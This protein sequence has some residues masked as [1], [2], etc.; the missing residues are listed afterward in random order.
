MGDQIDESTDR[1]GV[2]LDIPAAGAAADGPARPLDGGPKGAQHVLPKLLGPL[3]AEGPLQAD[4]PIALQR[5]HVILD[6]VGG[7]RHLGIDHHHSSRCWP[8]VLYGT[9]CGSPVGP[10]TVALPPDSVRRSSQTLRLPK[11]P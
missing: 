5:L 8:A 4:D 3:A 9:G 11:L 7:H 10:A 1:L 2:D 6:E